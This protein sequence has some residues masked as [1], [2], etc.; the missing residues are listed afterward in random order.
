MDSLVISVLISVLPIIIKGSIIWDMD[1]DLRHPGCVIWD[2]WDC[3]NWRGRL[4]CLRGIW[5][6]TLVWVNR[7]IVNW[8]Q[9]WVHISIRRV[10]Y[11]VVGLHSMMRIRDPSMFHSI[12]IVL[13]SLC[14]FHPLWTMK[15]RWLQRIYSWKWLD[16]YIVISI[17]VHQSKSQQSL[18]H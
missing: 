16:T 12:M 8:L 1:M 17:I 7:S 4:L 5:V 14:I 18:N 13:H 11:Q 3:V 15:C 10:L 2:C 6:A 9:N